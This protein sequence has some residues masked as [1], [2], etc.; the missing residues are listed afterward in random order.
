MGGS[1]RLVASGWFEDTGAKIRIDW[2]KYEGGGD[3]ILM[4]FK[5]KKHVTSVTDTMSH[6][7]CKLFETPRGRKFV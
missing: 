5:S 6:T 7:W 1:E 3:H 4:A 2:E